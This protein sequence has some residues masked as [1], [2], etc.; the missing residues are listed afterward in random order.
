MNAHKYVIFWVAC[1]NLPDCVRNMEFL[2]AIEIHCNGGQS[3]WKGR[4]VPTK[5]GLLSIVCLQLGLQKLSIKWSS[6]V[7]A[8]QGLLKYWNEWKDSWDFQNCPLCRGCPLLR[9]VGFHCKWHI[10]SYC[11][12]WTAEVYKYN[13]CM[14][15][16]CF[17][18]NGRVWGRIEVWLWKYY[19]KQW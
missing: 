8:I 5:S 6:R 11:K 13:L 1:T 17:E 10:V 7:S 4:W 16:H 15:F 3:R 14:W 18:N 12:Q 19:W 2:N 9:E